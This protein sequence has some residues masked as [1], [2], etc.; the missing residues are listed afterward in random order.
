M[1]KT[2]KVI[3][4]PVREKVPELKSTENA[5]KPKSKETDTDE[6]AEVL[7]NVR[8]ILNKLTPQ[9]FQPLMH[10]V[11]KLAINTEER[12]IG[13]INLIFEK[14]IDEPN[15]CEAYA[16]MCRVMSANR[17][18]LRVEKA[19][20]PPP[21]LE[22]RKVLLTRCQKEFE[23]DKSNEEKLQKLRDELEAAPEDKKRRD[24]SEPV[25]S[26]Q[27]RTTKDAG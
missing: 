4:L 16:N 3:K 23:K 11:Q 8:S 1:T 13:V 21:V 25:G 26:D 9:K 6:T 20:Q 19:G 15:F 17:I 7:R 5:W 27:Q 2:N 10:Q 12:L 24:K 18:E 22:F 14:A